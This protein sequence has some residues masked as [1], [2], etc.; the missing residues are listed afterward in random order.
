MKQVVTRIHEVSMFMREDCS[1]KL[2][3]QVWPHLPCCMI[4]LHAQRACSRMPLLNWYGWALVSIRSKC[5]VSAHYDRTSAQN[6]TSP[7]LLIVINRGS[8]HHQESHHVLAWSSQCRPRWYTLNHLRPGA[9]RWWCIGRPAVAQ[10]QTWIK[11][12]RPQPEDW[13][14]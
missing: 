2:T 13:K 5:I 4:T 10:V 12:H 1:F 9:L 8:I 11:K 14:S 6:E 3:S 7:A